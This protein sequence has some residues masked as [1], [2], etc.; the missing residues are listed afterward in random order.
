MLVNNGQSDPVNE[1]KLINILI[2]MG[3][4]KFTPKS[5]FQYKMRLLTNIKVG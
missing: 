1:I 4:S 2:D 3:V 5:I